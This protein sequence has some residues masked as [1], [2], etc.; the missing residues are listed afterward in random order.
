MVYIL[1]NNIKGLNFQTLFFL[2]AIIVQINL[3]G[4]TEQS[5]WS[6]KEV[7]Y[8]LPANIHDHSY[9]LKIESF[10]DL[11][12]QPLLF[13]YR[14]LI[15]DVDGNNCPFSPSCSSFFEE[16]IKRENLFIGV[17]MFAD[18]FSSDFNFVNRSDKYYR[19]P[20]GRFYDPVVNYD[21]NSIKYS[22]PPDAKSK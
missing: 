8:L 11:F 9:Q 13:V 17:M 2:F 1:L 19:M 16:A 4:Q 10:Q 12:I 3:N 21:L 14:V 5:K 6:K 7:S 15:S 20:S 18:R 22:L